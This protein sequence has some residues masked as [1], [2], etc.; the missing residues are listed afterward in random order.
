[1]GRDGSQSE[2]WFCGR[3]RV[4]WVNGIWVEGYAFYVGSE[5]NDY[6]VG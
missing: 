4:D 2:K 1:M 5:N 3:V 6:W